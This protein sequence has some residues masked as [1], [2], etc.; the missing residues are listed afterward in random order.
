M[1]KLEKYILDIRNM[2]IIS[3]KD[4]IESWEKDVNDKK[5]TYRCSFNNGTYLYIKCDKSELRLHVY[6]KYDHDEDILISRYFGM[7]FIKDKE[8]YNYVRKLSYHFKQKEIEEKLNK[9][10]TIMENGLEEIKK[11]YSKQFEKYVR[12]EKLEN[13]K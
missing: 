3:V 10:I 9:E 13:L 11:R 2:F 1:N 4:D 7:I 12:K 6:N 8:I 5:V